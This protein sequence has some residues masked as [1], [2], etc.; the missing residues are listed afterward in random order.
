M[1]ALQNEALKKKDFKTN[2]R[3][4]PSSQS[5]PKNF[6]NHVEKFETFIMIAI[7]VLA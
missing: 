4:W 1:V 7:K 5:V 3:V 6:Q 2:L